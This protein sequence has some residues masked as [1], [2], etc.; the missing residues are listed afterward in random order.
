MHPSVL[1]SVDDELARATSTSLTMGP[2]VIDS[3]CWYSFALPKKLHPGLYTSTLRDAPMPSAGSGSEGSMYKFGNSGKKQ[4]G[5]VPG[6]PDFP[7][8]WQGETSAEHNTKNTALKQRQEDRDPT[9]LKAAPRV[10]AKTTARIKRHQ[11]RMVRKA[12][13]PTYV[14][15]YKKTGGIGA[16]RELKRRLRDQR[17][18]RR[19]E[20]V[21]KLQERRR[22]KREMGEIC[23]GMASIKC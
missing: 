8:F 6:F 3:P 21:V 18:V 9:V 22:R 17:R 10:P 1:V 2:A 11:K 5:G 15:T 14:S 12:V 19:I 13:N 7:D 16:G 23:R 4:G 20:M